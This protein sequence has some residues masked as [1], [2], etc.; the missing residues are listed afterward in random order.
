MDLKE[1]KYRQ[2]W[3]LEQK[4]DHAVG[5]VEAFKSKTG[6]PLY[7]SFSGGKDS[8][9]LLDLCRRFIDSKIKA[10]FNNTGNEYPEIIKFIRETENVHIISPK[11]SVR[12]M[13]K[14]NG[15]PLI[16]KEQSQYIREAK[17]TKSE[18]LLDIRLKGT[19]RPGGRKSGCISKRWNFLIYESFMVSE[20]CCYILKKRPFRAYE[21]ETG[22]RPILGIMAEESRLRQQ[23]YI[24]RGGCNL[25]KTN[26]ESSFP[27]SIWTEQ[28]IWDY[29]HKFN[30]SYCPIYD[31]KDCLR[32]GCMFCGFGAH[33]DKNSR[34]DL[35]YRLHPN[36][37]KAMMNYTNNGISYRD[38]LHKCG[39]YLPD[40]P[41]ELSLFD[42]NNN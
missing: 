28:D 3:S 15:F 37:Y 31:N 41:K 30:V 7:V 1:L 8:T 22:E 5:A 39:V 23:S 4:I 25:F 9:V 32:T 34:F 38:A 16:S 29:I 6:R 36:I 10:V 33:L 26:H 42:F 11:V 20:K 12:E 40:D 2:S 13:I 17:S 19:I 18:K 24:R 27:L 21:K 14:E 35:V